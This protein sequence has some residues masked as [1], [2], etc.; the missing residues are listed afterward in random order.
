MITLPKDPSV[1]KNIHLTLER[2][3]GE[4]ETERVSEIT[5]PFDWA[6]AQKVEGVVSFYTTR[7]PTTSFELWNSLA[8]P[9]GLPPG[10]PWPPKKP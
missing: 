3:V 2:L 7:P 5:V 10:L 1:I 9:P 4:N 8:F 6:K